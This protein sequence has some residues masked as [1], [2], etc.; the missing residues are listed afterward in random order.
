MRATDRSNASDDTRA[1]IDEL[2]DKVR[3]CLDLTLARCRE[4]GRL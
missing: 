2:A 1:Q 4:E 3:R